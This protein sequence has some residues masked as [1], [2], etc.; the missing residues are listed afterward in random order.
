MHRWRLIRIMRSTLKNVAINAWGAS[1]ILRVVCTMLNVQGW[2]SLDS[3][4]AF[5]VMQAVTMMNGSRRV[6]FFLH[7]FYVRCQEK[8]Q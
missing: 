7:S 1:T 8:V 6:H 2:I 3:L 5:V 4:V